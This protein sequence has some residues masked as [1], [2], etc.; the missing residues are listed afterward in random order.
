MSEDK[1][2]PG[3]EGKQPKKR[4]DI[5]S[6]LKP[7]ADVQTSMGQLYLFPLRD[8][9]IGSYKRI[10]TGDPG[11]RIRE[12]LP[13]IASLSPDY[14]LEQERVAITVEQVGQLPDG[15]VEALAEAYASSSA[16]G[17]AREGGEE[18]EPLVRNQGETATSFLDRLLQKEI[19]KQASQM[20]KLR[21]QMLGSTRSIFDQV[22]N[23]SLELGKTWKNFERLS[24][25]TEL[26]PLPTNSL[27]KHNHLAEH[28]A[29]LA[30][31]R[32]ED[33]EII[34]LTGQMTA[35]SA[36]TLQ[37]LAEAA[38]TLL[39]KLDERDVNAKQT[40]KIQLWIAIGTVVISAVL[41]GASFWQDKVNNAFSDQWQADLLS[42]VKASNQRRSAMEN[43]ANSLK[44]KVQKLQHQTLELDEQLRAVRDTKPAPPAAHPK[45]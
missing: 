9:D 32:T 26:P 21:E 24:K 29:R 33:R 44:E 39:E 16:L 27:N 36:K 31:E 8:T 40:T 22:R 34:R 7:V 2:S 41:A 19:E 38:S 12:F 3:S 17:E 6:F 10:S 5:C 13:C 45:P 37:E 15:D 1:D 43:E 30:Q 42:E 28:H 14:S 11:G 4:L 18:H 23:S 35:Q 20:R 25:V